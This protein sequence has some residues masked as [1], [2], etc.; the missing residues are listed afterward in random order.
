MRFFFF[1]WGTEQ[2]VYGEPNKYSCV[3]CLKK[4]YVLIEFISTG[5]YC[6]SLLHVSSTDSQ[7]STDSHVVADKTY[8]YFTHNAIFP[9]DRR[10]YYKH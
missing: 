10:E 4:E 2:T 3:V 8:G 9:H 1:L 7:S 6:I 5:V